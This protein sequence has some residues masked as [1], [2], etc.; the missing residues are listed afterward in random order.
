MALSDLF[1]LNGF[2]Y[3][4]C[5]LFICF[6]VHFRGRKDYEPPRYMTINTAIDQLLEISQARD[7]PGEFFEHLHHSRHEFQA[8]IMR[9]LIVFILKFKYT[10]LE[11]DMY[12]TLF[13][14]Y[15]IST[16]LACL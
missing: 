6:F 7:E 12:F 13:A 4:H 2:V 1:L 16:F 8:W 3:I 11:L 9:L 10:C 14:I 15:L 5:F